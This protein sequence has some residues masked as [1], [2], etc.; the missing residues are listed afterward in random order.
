MLKVKQRTLMIK[1]VHSV[2]ITIIRED[3]YFLCYCY[4]CGSWKEIE[5]FQADIQ[6][7]SRRTLRVLPHAFEVNRLLLTPE[8]N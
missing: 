2:Y 3:F 7:S 4:V 6:Q 8:S 1:C 5:W